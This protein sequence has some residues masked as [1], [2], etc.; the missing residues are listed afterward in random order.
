MQ[1]QIKRI[2]E[3]LQKEKIIGSNESIIRFEREHGG[4]INDSYLLTYSSGKLFVKINSRKDLP[5][6][7]LCEKKGLEK[8][9]VSTDLKVP[10]VISLNE[11]IENES[12]FLILEYLDEAKPAPLFWSNFGKEL[13]T[14][15]QNTSDQFGLDYD[16]YIGSLRQSNNKH[17]SWIDFFAVERLE[18]QYKLARE[19][20]FLDESFGLDLHKL[21]NKLPNLI[22]QEKPALLH[23]DLWSGNFRVVGAGQAAIFDPAIYYGHRE[24]DLAMMH[25]F[26]GFD[27]SLFKAYNEVF[28]LELGWEERIDLFNLYPL[29]VHVNLFS[30][31]YVSRARQVL[32]RYL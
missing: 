18:A 28:P 29:L 25:L 30:G 19:K 8:L 5:G 20:N 1:N 13:A 31:S 7:F 26:G 14:I 3:H 22:P 4:S 9:K 24:V 2:E 11:G 10:K 12:D 27:R 21:Y 32:N 16:N 17:D 15:H 23:G 6:F